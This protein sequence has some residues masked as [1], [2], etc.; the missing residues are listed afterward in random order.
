MSNGS[1]TFAEEYVPEIL[2]GEKTATVRLLDDDLP[3]HDDT[4]DAVLPDGE[5]FATIRVTRKAVCI[6][7]EALSVIELFMGDHGADS[8]DDLLSGLK[9]HYDRG[10][11]PGS[12]VQVLVF[13]RVDGG[14]HE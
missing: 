10:L 11:S 8:V 7:V 6:A 5:E 2:R 3:G 12:Y 9:G 14:E 1:L 4:V 13:E